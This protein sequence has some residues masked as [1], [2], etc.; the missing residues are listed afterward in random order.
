MVVEVASRTAV[1]LA[2]VRVELGLRWIEGWECLLRVSW[3]ER[4]ESLNMRGAW[5]WGFGLKDGSS[6]CRLLCFGVVVVG[7]S[8]GIKNVRLMQ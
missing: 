3:G 7:M 8:F 2:L 5:C 1:I 4:V 6:V